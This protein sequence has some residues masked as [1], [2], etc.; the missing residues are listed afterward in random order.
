MAFHSH[1]IT[2]PGE[3]FGTLL[4][5]EGKDALPLLH[6]ISTQKLDDLAP[7]RARATL[8]CDYRGRLLHRAWVAVTSDRAVWLLRDDAPTRALHDFLE[9][10]VFREEVHFGVPREDWSVRLM[11]REL[12]QEAPEPGAVRESGG[13]PHEARVRPE[14]SLVLV[15]PGAP[16]ADSGLERARILAGL[17]RHGHEITESFNPFEVGLATEVHL[18]KGC[19]TGQEALLRMI[20]YGGVRR[21]LARVSGAGSPPGPASGRPEGRV[22]GARTVAQRAA[23]GAGRVGARGRRGRVVGAGARAEPPR[24]RGVADGLG[25]H[26]AR[27]AGVGGELAGGS[28]ERREHE[29]GP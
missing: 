25:R 9:R 24:G 15:P 13:L 7:G 19:Y 18:D 14:F 27:R 11:P 3:A 16:P 10:F 2:R 5:L 21:R 12:G 4:R 23:P 26:G 22:A 29:I 17:P 6:R 1:P 20:T 28:L 8:F